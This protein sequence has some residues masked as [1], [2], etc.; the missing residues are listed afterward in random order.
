VNIVPEIGTSLQ[1]KLK[2][3]T[4]LEHYWQDKAEKFSLLLDKVLIIIYVCL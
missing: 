2:D 3:L 1:E 4:V